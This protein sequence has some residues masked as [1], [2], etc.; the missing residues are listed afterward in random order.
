M[1]TPRMGLSAPVYTGE[2]FTVVFQNDAQHLRRTTCERDEQ[3]QRVAERTAARRRCL[4]Q[5]EAGGFCGIKHEHSGRLRRA[6]GWDAA[7]GDEREHSIEA[8][9]LLS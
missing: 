2:L 4:A 8:S 5:S 7:C 6:K 1:N 3:L 9:A